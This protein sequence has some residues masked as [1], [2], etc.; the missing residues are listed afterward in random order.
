MN[1]LFFLKPKAEVAY[2]YEDFSMRQGLEKLERSGYTA[3]PVIN[4]QGAYIGTITA[5]VITS[6]FSDA[7]VFGI[8]IIVLLV[9]PSGLMGEPE[10]EK[11]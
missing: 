10:S 8:L 9:K 4:R 7:I 11:V 2:L 1:I 6:A 3:I 5:G